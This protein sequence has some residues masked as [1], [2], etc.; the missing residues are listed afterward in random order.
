MTWNRIAAYL[1]D[2]LILF[3]L[4]VPFMDFGTETRIQSGHQIETF[5]FGLNGLPLVLWIAGSFAYFVLME[6]LFAGTLGKLLL[7]IRVTTAQGE[8]CSF[9]RALLRNLVRPVDAFPYLIP[10]LLGFLVMGTSQGR[11]R[12]GDKLA[13]TMVVPKQEIVSLQGE[14]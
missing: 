14:N 3:L 1:V 7:G 2:S 13:G 10:Y 6:W 11:Q 8:I 5:N 4:A 9:G 12:L